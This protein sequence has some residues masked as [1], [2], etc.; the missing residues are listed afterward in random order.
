[1]EGV[2]VT[3]GLKKSIKSFPPTTMAAGNYTVLAFTNELIDQTV[4]LVLM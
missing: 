2:E 1:V 3:M 4:S